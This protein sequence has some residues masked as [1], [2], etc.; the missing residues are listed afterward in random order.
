MNKFSKQYTQVISPGRSIE[1]NSG[2]LGR[3]VTGPWQVFKF[4]FFVESLSSISS[5]V[6]KIY[7]HQMW[8]SGDLFA[9]QTFQDIKGPHRIAFQCGPLAA[10]S[11][12][13]IYKVYCKFIILHEMIAWDEIFWDPLRPTTDLQA[14]GHFPPRHLLA[15]L[16]NLSVCSSCWDTFCHVMGNSI[17]DF[18][19]RDASCSGVALLCWAS[20]CIP[21]G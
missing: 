20:P 13:C 4:S 2:P 8:T 16:S 17:S 6:F 14:P 12:P 15:G 5:T 21:Q 1:R 11:R 7:R 19:R 9:F 3:A 10:F 18:S